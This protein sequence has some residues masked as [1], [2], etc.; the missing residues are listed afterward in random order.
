MEWKSIRVL[1][2]KEEVK[3]LE[4]DLAIQLPED[5]KQKILSINGGALKNAYIDLPKLGKVPYSRNVSLS[6]KSSFSI[7]DLCSRETIAKNQLFPFGTVGNGDYFCFD[8]K[9]H[10]V[11]LYLHE[12]LKI[13]QVCKTYSELLSMIEY[14]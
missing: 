13:M 10:Q 5:Y 8:L 2:T 12:T 11:V 9:N 3:Q 7:Y 6:K 14:E 4:K 1:V